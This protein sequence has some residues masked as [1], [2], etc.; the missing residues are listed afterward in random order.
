MNSRTGQRMRMNAAFLDDLEK[1]HDR[2]GI[3][4][5]AHRMTV[6]GKRLQLIAASEDLTAPPKESQEIFATAVKDNSELHIIERTGH[7]FGVEHPFKGMT[8]PF[9]HAM[10]ITIDFLKRSLAHVSAG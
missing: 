9:E 3:I 2:L 4:K 5:A 10:A 1:H 7:T 8:Q 6:G